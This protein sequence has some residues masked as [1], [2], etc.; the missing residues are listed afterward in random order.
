[1]TGEKKND[2]IIRLQIENREQL[3]KS[4]AENFTEK[5]GSKGNRRNTRYREPMK[6]A[7]S[8]DKLRLGACVLRPVDFRM[9]KPGKVK[10]CH[11]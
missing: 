6:D 10:L 4:E 8:C 7:A 9:G 3:R 2:I 11:H 5:K 1:M